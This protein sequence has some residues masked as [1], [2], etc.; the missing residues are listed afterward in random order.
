L[1]AFVASRL[2][3]IQALEAENLH[4]SYDR[5]KNNLKSVMRRNQRTAKH[6]EGYLRNAAEQTYGPEKAKDEPTIEAILN[7]LDMYLQE[8]V[9]FAAAFTKE[10][11]QSISEAL[12]IRNSLNGR[13]Q[14][15]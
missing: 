1:I 14:P 15:S 7:R 4:G 5:Q 2:C 3:I 10:S 9:T 6:V 11:E 13:D 8:F 12:K